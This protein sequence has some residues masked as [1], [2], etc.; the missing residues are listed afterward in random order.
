MKCCLIVGG[1]VVLLSLVGPSEAQAAT[2]GIQGIQTAAR[3]MLD[4]VQMIGYF[5]AVIL[6]IGLVVSIRHESGVGVIVSLLFGGVSAAILLGA[7]DIVNFI[8]P[9]AASAFTGGLL[10]GPD[11]LQAWWEL[12]QQVLTISGLTV[13]IRYGRR[14]H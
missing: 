5:F 1:L 3:S 2:K 14:E 9:G 7:E 11:L 4:T 13:A 8:K 12:G 6:I 10:P